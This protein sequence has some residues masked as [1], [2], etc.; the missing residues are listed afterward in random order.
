MDL[1]WS[2]RDRWPATSW[3]WNLTTWYYKA[4][5]LGMVMLCECLCFGSGILPVEEQSLLGGVLSSTNSLSTASSI[6]S[7]YELAVLDLLAK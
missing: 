1:S 2:F 3:I 4:S 6:I 5:F 7:E